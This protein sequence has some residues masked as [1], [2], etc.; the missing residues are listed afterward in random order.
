M[1]I[2]TNMDTERNRKHDQNEGSL[3][4]AVERQ[5]GRIPS[6]GYFGLAVGSMVASAGI[7]AFSRNKSFANFVGMWA[8]SLLVIGLYNKVVKLEA[9]LQRQSLH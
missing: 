3:T 9:T 6:L 1:D 7:A 8:P 5:T 2:S 4:A